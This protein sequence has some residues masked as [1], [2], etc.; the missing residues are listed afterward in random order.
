[1][2]WGR[3][4]TIGWMENS[5]RNLPSGNELLGD[6]NGLL[7]DCFRPAK[8]P[9]ILCKVVTW[10][11]HNPLLPY[12]DKTLQWLSRQN[13]LVEISRGGVYLEIIWSISKYLSNPK[14]FPSGSHDLPTP[15]FSPWFQQNYSSRE[16]RVVGWPLAHKHMIQSCSPNL[17]TDLAEEISRAFMT[18]FPLAYTFSK[19]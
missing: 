15:L 14:C 11:S 8:W 17:V 6:Y 16:P 4:A 12:K 18:P 9:T 19:F 1:M 2:A 13:S 10:P 3:G 5:I 7:G